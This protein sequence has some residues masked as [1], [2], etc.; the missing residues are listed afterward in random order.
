MRASL[1]RRDIVYIGKYAFGIAIIVLHRNFDLDVILL[2]LNVQRFFIKRSLILIEVFY[3][4]RKAT[5]KFEFRA[6]LFPTLAFIR[7]AK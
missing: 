5:F 3:K 4:I 6:L 1:G 7:N 2:P